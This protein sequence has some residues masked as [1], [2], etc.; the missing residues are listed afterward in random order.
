MPFSGYE[1]GHGTVFT[2][3]LNDYAV[4]IT[5]RCALLRVNAKKNDPDTGINNVLL[6]KHYGMG[7][8]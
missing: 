1:W 3:E 8:I 4:W 6:K 7:A 5:H 2:R